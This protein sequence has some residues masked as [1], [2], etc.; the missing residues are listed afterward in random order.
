MDEYYQKNEAE[1]N[2]TQDVRVTNEYYNRI[3]VVEYI[4]LFFS[5]TGI[6]L[7][8]I[9]NEIK[10]LETLSTDNENI[11]LCYI[12]ACS[13]SLVLTLY[14]RY[15]LHLKWYVT[16]G[17]LTEYD[18]LF[19]TGWW[20]M[21]VIEQFIALLAPYP[22]LQNIRYVE[23]NPNYFVTISYDLNQIMLCLCFIR[24]YIH[25]RYTLIVSKFMN[26]RSSRV[27]VMNGCEADN[28]FAIKAIMKQ[29]PYIFIT[30]TLSMT[31]FL[32]GY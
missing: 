29:R 15:D 8:I 16:R 22:F 5:S 24:I 4:A 21:M 1:Q 13:F 26:P 31:I 12:T 20:K 2:S 32:F 9:M 30:F 7:S 27:C 14:Y 10:L 6:G 25:L 19:S 18:N 11:F 17:L 23:Y 3:M 28:T